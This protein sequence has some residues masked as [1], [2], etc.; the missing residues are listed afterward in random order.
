MNPHHFPNGF[1]LPDVKTLNQNSLILATITASDW[2]PSM[3]LKKIFV[4][5]LTSLFLLTGIRAD[6]GRG[7]TGT[8]RLSWSEFTNTKTE[9]SD[10][11]V[12]KALFN[13]ERDNEWTKY[14]VRFEIT[15]KGNEH[16]KVR[17]LISIFD[18][19]QNLIFAGGEDK[20]IDGLE[21]KE[22]KAKVKIASSIKFD[23]ETV[24]LRL[25]WE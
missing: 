19:S 20:G 16:K 5:T 9:K 15:N 10:L 24:Y 23:P 25:W 7:D 2:M 13:T 14:E 4:L 1:A 12:G 17:Y 6:E 18:K 3:N 11:S 22:A 8:L 21:S